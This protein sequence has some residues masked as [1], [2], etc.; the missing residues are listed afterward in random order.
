MTTK[1]SFDAHT[2]RYKT[3]CV[4]LAC[5]FVFVLVFYAVRIYRLIVTPLYIWWSLFCHLLPGW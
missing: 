3:F 5:A 1:Q 2:Q 4:F